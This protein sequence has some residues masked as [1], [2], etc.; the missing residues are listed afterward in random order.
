MSTKLA[1]IRKW[2]QLALLKVKFKIE[3]PTSQSEA[4]K[5]P[6]K[7]RTKRKKTASVEGI[8]ET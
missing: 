4:I 7:F 2:I 6:Q 5:I 3:N 8:I 1:T